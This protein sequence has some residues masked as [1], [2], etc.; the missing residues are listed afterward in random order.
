MFFLQISYHN[1]SV[2]YMPG[3]VYSVEKPSRGEIPR[4]YGEGSNTVRLLQYLV[5]RFSD[6]ASF[7]GTYTANRWRVDMSMC[8]FNVNNSIMHVMVSS[9]LA[10][11][12]V[13]SFFVLCLLSYTKV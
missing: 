2:S 7:S 1:S 5:N 11:A 13:S 3:R 8:M 12:W 9:I 10:Y 4:G 6:V